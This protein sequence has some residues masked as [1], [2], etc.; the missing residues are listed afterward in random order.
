MKTL[1]KQV[2]REQNKTFDFILY[3]GLV[4][5]IYETLKFKKPDTPKM[6]FL[7][8]PN[9]LQ[10]SPIVIKSSIL[11]VADFLASASIF[12]SHFLDLFRD[13]LTVHWVIKVTLKVY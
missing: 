6:L 3:V 12:I 2:L 13:H 10:E 5:E 9:G 1:V 7:I 4:F 11:K 8:M